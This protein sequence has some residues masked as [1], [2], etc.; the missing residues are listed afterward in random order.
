MGGK[1]RVR[2]KGAAYPGDEVCSSGKFV[3]EKFHEGKRIVSCT[4][5]LSN[6]R[7]QELIAG[8]AT[9]NLPMDKEE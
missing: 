8:I 7:G 2:F 9:I 3:K 5:S 1:L 4:V 6:Q